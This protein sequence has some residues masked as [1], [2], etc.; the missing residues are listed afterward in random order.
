MLALSKLYILAFSGGSQGGL[1]DVN[2]GLIIW[3][4]ITF[5]CL[6]FVLTKLAWKPM[7]KS[8]QDR[9]NFIKDSLEKAEEAQIEAERLLEENKGNL[10]KAEEEAQKVIAQGREYADKL[11][12]QILDESK[13]EAKKIVNDATAE[14]ER[15]NLEAFSKLKDEIAEIAVQSA[16]KII[17]AN[18]DVDK[19]KNIVNK[20]IED[21]AKKN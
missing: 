21:L 16:E 7:L 8:L 9:E 14:I 1:L 13:A 19:Q 10:A 6:L 17:L 5:A 4:I 11:K 20:F 18:L 12:T 3:T 2:P 15:K